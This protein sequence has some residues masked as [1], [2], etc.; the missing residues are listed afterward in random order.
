MSRSVYLP[1][2]PQGRLT[3]RCDVSGLCPRV[4]TNGLVLDSPGASLAFAPR[5]SVRANPAS[6]Q[7]LSPRLVS[8]TVPRSLPGCQWL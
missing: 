5:R 8:P 1:A 6:K 2:I 7:H 3:C 4:L